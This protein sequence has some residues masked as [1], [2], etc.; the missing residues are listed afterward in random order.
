MIKS[1]N[2][3]LYIP[4]NQSGKLLKAKRDYLKAVD[5]KYGTQFTIQSIT[6]P[7]KGG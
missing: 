6:K 1:K 4:L 3:P 2:T 5:K 7:E